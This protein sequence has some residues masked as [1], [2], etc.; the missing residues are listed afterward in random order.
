MDFGS[1]IIQRWWSVNSPYLI[2]KIDGQCWLL[3][4]D[5]GCNCLELF[6]IIIIIIII[7]IV[8]V[9]VV[10]VVVVLIEKHK[11]GMA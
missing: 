4:N 11:D 9:V 7:I 3:D 1:F 10:V 6:L 5:D 8:V 2:V